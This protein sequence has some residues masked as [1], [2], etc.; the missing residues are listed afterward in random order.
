[1]IFVERDKGGRVTGLYANR[2]QG[3]AEEELPDDHPD[4]VAFTNR[5]SAPRPTLTDEQKLSRIFEREGLTMEKV[6]EL[7][8]R[9]VTSEVGAGR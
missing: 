2:Q 9:T 3:Y 7:L 1:M 8:T 5:L 4:V 6:R